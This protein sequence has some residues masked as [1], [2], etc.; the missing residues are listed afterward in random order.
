MQD[1]ESLKSFDVKNHGY[2][3]ERL[4]QEIEKGRNDDNRDGQSE[5]KEL[6]QNGI[7]NQNYEADNYEGII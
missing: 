4:L 6:I 7:I 5:L 3:I 1:Y 2:F